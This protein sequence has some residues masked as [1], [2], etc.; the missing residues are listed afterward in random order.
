MPNIRVHHCKSP[1]CKRNP[2]PSPTGNNFG[3]L[4]FGSSVCVESV[5]PVVNKDHP[6]FVTQNGLLFYI[7][8]GDYAVHYAEEYQ[9]TVSCKD[10][11]L[12]KSII[13]GIY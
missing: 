4:L 8:R 13:E 10:E 1:K 7:I 11:Q 6:F 2:K 9:Y 12:L 5:H 3:Y